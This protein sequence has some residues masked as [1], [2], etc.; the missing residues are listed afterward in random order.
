[1]R[2]HAEGCF[3]M[4]TRVHSSLHD[5]TNDGCTHKGIGDEPCRDATECSGYDELENC[6]RDERMQQKADS[7]EYRRMDDVDRV[8]AAVEPRPEC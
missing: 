2:K 3:A 5:A 8:G 1:M 4:N 6:G 7:D